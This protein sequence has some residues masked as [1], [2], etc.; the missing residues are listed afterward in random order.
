M[1]NV[2][3]IT[4]ASFPKQGEHKGLRVCVMFHYDASSILEGTVVRDDSEAP[5]VTIV[6]LDDGRYVLS[7]ECQY[8]VIRDPK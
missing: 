8:A 2:V 3:N 1:G 4:A 5:W 7:R 6:H